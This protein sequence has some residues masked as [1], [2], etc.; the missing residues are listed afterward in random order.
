MDESRAEHFRQWRE[1][2]QAKRKGEPPPPPPPPPER[3]D[4]TILCL[5]VGV[6]FFP[7]NI[8]EMQRIS[9]EVFK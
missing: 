8:A 4:G 7:V 5:Q 1:S 3:D 2:S 6:W 9:W